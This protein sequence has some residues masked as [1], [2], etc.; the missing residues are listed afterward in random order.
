M[1]RIKYVILVL[2]LLLAVNVKAADDCDSKEF[3]R[4]KNLAKKVEFDYEYKMVNDKALFSINAVNLN[5]ELRVLII[6]DYYNNKYK[7]FV[8]NST[9]TASINN[10]EAGSK[11]VITIKGFVP[12]WCS[13]KTV[14]TKTVKI[15]YYNYYYDEEKCDGHED[16]KYCKLLIEK[17]ITQKEFDRQYEEYLKK[18][19]TNDKPQEEEIKNN[20]ELYLIIAG[21]VLVVIIL[22]VYFV[23]VRRRIKKNS[24]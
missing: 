5:P 14:L 16:F 24:L 20:M 6:E 15:P 11:V 8:D 10:F 18:N 17:N 9:H 3:T 12:N 22:V 1:K 7:E 23:I 2:L 21:A 13:G 19:E 4:L